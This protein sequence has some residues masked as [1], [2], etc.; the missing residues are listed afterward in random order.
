M[1]KALAAAGASGK[2]DA[3]KLGFLQGARG[4]EVKIDFSFPTAASVLFEAVYIPG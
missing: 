2:T 3:P 1:K 4:E